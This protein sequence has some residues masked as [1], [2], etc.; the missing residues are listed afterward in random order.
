MTEHAPG[1]TIERL[2]DALAAQDLD[3]S[4]ALYHA[5]AVW[6]IHVP[7]WDTTL[8]GK[9]D[10][11]ERLI[12]W[13]ITRDQ[14]EIVGYQIIDH[15]DTVALRWEQRWRD[16]MDGVPC[17]CHQSHFFQV[18][19]GLISRQWMYCAGI[20]AIEMEA[21]PAGDLAAPV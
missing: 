19:D 10:I 20:T 1:A 15:D 8:V 7:G 4:M 11:A 5:D 17:T 18:R 13:F 3:A 12:P 6:E 21:E 9:P 16:A 2:V 14:Y